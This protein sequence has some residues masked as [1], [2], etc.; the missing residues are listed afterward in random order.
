MFR[1]SVRFTGNERVAATRTSPESFL[2][3][4]M[5]INWLYMSACQFA[6][7]PPNLHFVKRTQLITMLLCFLCLS[8]SIV[9]HQCCMI[10]FLKF[11]NKLLSFI[12][13]YITWKGQLEINIWFRTFGSVI[14][15]YRLVLTNLRSHFRQVYNWTPYFLKVSFSDIYTC[16]IFL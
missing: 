6:F 15:Y 1:H 3:I 9:I 10:L 2:M 7:S 4:E 16:Q 12:F 5:N 8:C 13:L 14:L 11:R